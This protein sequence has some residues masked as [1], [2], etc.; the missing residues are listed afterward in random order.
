MII[1]GV[2]PYD[3]GNL[4]NH[5]SLNKCTLH[6]T[7]K[8]IE[9]SCRTISVAFF[10]SIFSH[11]FNVIQWL[12]GAPPSLKFVKPVNTLATVY[13]PNQPEVHS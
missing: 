3:Q 1:L 13:T 7:P 12:Q 10:V 4:Q 8:Q 11:M 6:R 2:A 5:V 9:K